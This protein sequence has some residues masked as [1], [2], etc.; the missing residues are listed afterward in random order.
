MENPKMKGEQIMGMATVVFDSERG[1]GFRKP[2]GLYVM[3]EPQFMPC[4]KL[5]IRL[6]IC[7]CCG[8]GIKFARS[9]T[10][11]EP[12]KLVEPGTCGM[13]GCEDCVLS[14]PPERAGLIWIGEKFYPTPES[15]IREGM[16]QGVS[17]RIQTVPHGFKVGETWILVAHK[18]AILEGTD[19]KGK[20]KYT[21]G[22]FQA[23]R[24]NRIEYVVKGD[25]TEDELQKLI[26]RGITPVI[27]KQKEKAKQMPVQFGVPHPES[28]KP[29]QFGV[30]ETK[31]EQNN[32]VHDMPKGNAEEHEEASASPSGD[33]A[34]GGEEPEPTGAD[35][36]SSEAV[37]EED[38]GV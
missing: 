30:E 13:G 34:F 23:F 24:P 35:Q 32:D 31:G 8:Q 10:W 18:K 22:I 6:D 25:E 4:G 3:C 11:I 26:D 28:P 29:E 21:P 7:P 36:V 9:W 12:R 2:G 14:N 17:R 16:I 38:P 19:E 20:A 15:W 1:C 33:H 5:P 27:V 37:A